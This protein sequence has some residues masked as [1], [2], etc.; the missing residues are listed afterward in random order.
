MQEMLGTGFSAMLGLASDAVLGL[1]EQ[2]GDASHPAAVAQWL[3]P[4]LAWHVARLAFGW[5]AALACPRLRRKCGSAPLSAKE[6]AEVTTRA[7]YVLQHS[8]LSLV[9]GLLCWRAGWLTGPGFDIFYTFPFPHSLLAEHRLAVRLFYQLQGGAHLESA[10]VLVRGVLYDG[11]KG[12][13]MMLIHHAATLFLVGASW[14]AGT[15]EVGCT[16][17]FLHD[18]SDI[19]IDA[20]KLVRAWGASTLSQVPVFL[21]ALFS[22]GA[23]RC[24]YLPLH[25]LIPGWQMF[26]AM[27]FAQDPSIHCYGPRGAGTYGL[28]ALLGMS[29]LQVLHVLWFKQLLDK[30]LSA[31]RGRGNALAIP[32]MCAP[33]DHQKRQ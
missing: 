7:F 11:G 5:L 4:V 22:W 19:G 6:Q 2:P 13:R 14:A 9:G 18:A 25:V 15:Y 10:Y 1:A 30:G 23:S 12:Q 32:D 21:V 33:A 24:V 8:C 31:L 3:W 26:Y 17:F 20:L 29:V 27:C 28:A 16:M